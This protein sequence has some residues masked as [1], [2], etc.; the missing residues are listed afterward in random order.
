[1]LSTSSAFSEVVFPTNNPNYSCALVL[2]PQRTEREIINAAL[3]AALIA[4]G[5]CDKRENH[6]QHGVHNSAVKQGLAKVR[7]NLRI[8]GRRLFKSWD[9]VKHGTIKVVVN[10]HRLTDQHTPCQVGFL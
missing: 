2:A 4:A 3:I 8:P 9:L 5:R 6:A 1:M 10:P 7:L